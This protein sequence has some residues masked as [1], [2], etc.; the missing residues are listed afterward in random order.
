[1]AATTPSAAETSRPAKRPPLAL[2][3]HDP[4]LAGAEV[5]WSAWYYP[6]DEDVPTSTRQKLIVN[7]LADSIRMLLR[8]EHRDEHVGEDLLFAWYEK[9]PNDC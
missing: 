2:V 4:K 9:D 6:E 5:D 1:M 3:L 8:E 7:T